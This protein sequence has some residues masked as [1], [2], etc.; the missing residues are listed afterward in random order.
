M[1]FK[2]LPQHI[3]DAIVKLTTDDVFQHRFGTDSVLNSIDEMKENLPEEYKSILAVLELNSFIEGKAAP[4]ITPGMWALLWIA[5]SPFV[6]NEKYADCKDTDIDFFLYLL[7]E[8]IGTGNLSELFAKSINYSKEVLKIT[9]EEA[10]NIILKSIKYAFRPLKLFPS[11]NNAGN[12]KPEYGADWLS[13]LVV[14]VHEMTGYTPTYILKNLSLTACCYYFAQ[15]RRKQG[16]QSIYKRSDKE[17]L[18]MQDERC[19]ELI[20]E[21]LVELNVFPEDEIKKW[22]NLMITPTDVNNSI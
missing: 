18:E 2:E 4:S 5:Q 10:V 16:D 1:Y 7:Y 14:R 17:I 6:I 22:K 20:C 3:K 11:G 12:T 21:R 13:S 19:C 9:L 8:G 15:W